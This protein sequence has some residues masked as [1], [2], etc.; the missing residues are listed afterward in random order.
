MSRIVPPLALIRSGLAEYFEL[1]MTT[2]GVVMAILITLS[3]LSRGDQ[4]LR[5]ASEAER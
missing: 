2:V 3:E 1:F 5:A 4:D